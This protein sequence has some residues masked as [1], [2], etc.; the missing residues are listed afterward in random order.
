MNGTFVSKGNRNPINTA[1]VEVRDLS[2]FEQ[3]LSEAIGLPQGQI[4]SS[5]ADGPSMQD[6]FRKIPKEHLDSYLYWRKNCQNHTEA[7]RSALR[8]HKDLVNHPFSY[9]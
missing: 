3:K 5:I 9:S 4:L 1:L 2:W 7:L 8:D 6:L